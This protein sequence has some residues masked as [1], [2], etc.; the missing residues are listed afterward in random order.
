M[1]ISHTETPLTDAER[2]VVDAINASADGSIAEV[3]DI[4]SELTTGPTLARSAYWSLIS[5]GVVVRGSSTVRLREDFR[6]EQPRERKRGEPQQ[7]WVPLEKVGVRE[8][9]ARINA[10][11]EELVEEVRRRGGGARWRALSKTLARRHGT[12]FEQIQ[13]G[14]VAADGSRIRLVDGGTVMLLMQDS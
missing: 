4:A 10:L 3:I 8:R 9:D 13:Y 14:V 12:T 2:A 7:S 5:R 1:T 11:V 6:S